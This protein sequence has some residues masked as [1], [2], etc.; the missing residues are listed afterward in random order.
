VVLLLT[1]L[2]GI[3]WT[4]VCIDSVGVGFKQKTYTCRSPRSV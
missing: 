4:I 1:V 3:A 2:S